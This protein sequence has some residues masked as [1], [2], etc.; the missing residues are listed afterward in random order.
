[1]DKND[2]KQVF[3]GE[4][5]SV[6][7][8]E[9]E[10]FDGSIRIFEKIGRPNSANVFGVLPDKRIMLV[11]DQQPGREVEGVL[12]PAGGQIDEGETPE[13]GATREFF[14]ETGYKAGLL[15]PWFSYSPSS[16]IMFTVH[17]FIAK[18]IEKVTEPEQSA[19]E[20]TEVR[21]FTFDEFL[22]L[23]QN[24]SLRDTRIRITLLEA[25]LDPKKKNALHQ[26]FYG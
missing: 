11:W 26:L 18:N 21:F 4:I 23:G 16:K 1:M 22:L 5:F 24:E 7:Q 15:T 10:M 8:W 6:W 13:Q 25:Q 12:T 2:M 17:F 19:G 14:E 3:Q 9:Q 20:R